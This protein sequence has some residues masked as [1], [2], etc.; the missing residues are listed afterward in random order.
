MITVIPIKDINDIKELYSEF[1]KPFSENA[2]VTVARN[3]EEILGC[4][5]Y[6]L[7]EE[8]IIINY[9]TPENDIMLADGIL[10]SALHIADYR[11]INAAFYSETAP[12]NL[13]KTLDFIKNEQ[14]M[15]LKIEK[16]HESSCSCQKNNK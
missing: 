15:S 14:E 6:N 13:F 5:F 9:L 3:G 12:I 1:N 11:G 16:L 8:K 10:R 7:D 4:C 2:G